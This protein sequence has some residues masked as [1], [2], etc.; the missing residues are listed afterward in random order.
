MWRENSVWAVA[1]AGR[2]AVSSVGGRGRFAGGGGCLAGGGVG[3]SGVEEGRRRQ[4]KA[5]EGRRSG[6]LDLDRTVKTVAHG[7]KKNHSFLIKKE[8]IT[9]HKLSQ[10]RWQSRSPTRPRRAQDSA[11]SGTP[12]VE[13]K[14][15]PNRFSTPVRRPPTRANSERHLRRL[16]RIVSG[17]LGSPPPSASAF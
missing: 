13:T 5:R 4:A 12:L 1:V 11:R 16:L 8:K 10:C 9:V 17:P 7:E 15:T 6:P 2:R 3:H 14:A